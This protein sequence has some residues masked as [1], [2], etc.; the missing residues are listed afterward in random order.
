MHDSY[1]TCVRAE[2]CA[3]IL[4]MLIQHPMQ[5]H[6]LQKLS[7]LLVSAGAKHHS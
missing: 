3:V 5:M 6:W 2:L 1:A 7:L 4:L